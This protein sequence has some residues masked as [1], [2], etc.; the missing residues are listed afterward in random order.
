VALL[1]DDRRADRPPN[2]TFAYQLGERRLY[3]SPVGVPLFTNNETH[4]ER[5]YGPR[6][7]SASPHTKDAFHRY[8]VGGDTAAVNP[9]RTGT[10]ACL[11][12]ASV[13]PAG[14]SQVW[15][16][17][18]TP[19]RHENPLDDVDAIVAQR[20]ADADEVYAAAHPPNASDDERLVQRQ[21][22]AGMLWTKKI[23]LF[24]VHQWLNGDDPVHPPPDGRRFIR[25]THWHH[26]N[27]MR[28]L[29]LPDGWEYPWFAAWDL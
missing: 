11:Q 21:A 28:V 3:G 22:L 19:E 12:Y 20:K 4:C 8:I 9:E 18:L 7:R 29:S 25:N 27:S 6:A 13:I 5:C 2:L 24:D 17:R 14:A 10:K 23:Y 26:L 1:A 16:F 15:R